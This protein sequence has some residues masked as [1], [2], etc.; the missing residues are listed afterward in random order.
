MA[1]YYLLSQQW[2]KAATAAA[3]ARANYTIMDSSSS[4][5]YDGFVTVNNV[6]WMWGFAHTTETQTTYASFFSMISNIAPGYA[7]MGY[8]P[9][10]IDAKL[11]SQIPEEDGRKN[12]STDQKEIKINR[13]Q[14]HNYHT[15][16]LNSDM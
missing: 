12:G 9:R 1:R 7:G 2:E 10:L 6:E 3:K 11:Y 16:T 13:Q 5:L 8:A 15:Q 4:G 14:Q